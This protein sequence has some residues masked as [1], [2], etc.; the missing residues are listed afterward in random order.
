[1]LSVKGLALTSGIAIGGCVLI[2]GFGPLAAQDVYQYPS[3]F[4]GGY[5]SMSSGGG[6]GK[7]YMESYF[8]PP[9]TA[10]PSYPAWSPDGTIIAFESDRD[11]N[12][13]IYLMLSL[14]HI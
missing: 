3:S 4:P 11:G 2:M 1:M 13:E 14:I 7:M 8:P 12:D 6:A 9:V 5:P 10:S